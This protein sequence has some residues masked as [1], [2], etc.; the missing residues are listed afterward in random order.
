MEPVVG[1]V[2]HPE[3]QYGLVILSYVI[4]VFGSFV[5]L[6]CAQSM[7]RP[8]GKTDWPMTIGAAISLGGVGIW[9]MH[10][11][12]MIAYKVKVDIGYALIPTAISLVAAIV[13][14]G[15]ALFLAGGRGYFRVSGWLMGSVLA[16]VG[17][18]V[19]H[20]LGTYAM[21]LRA[22][23]T[24]EPEM[25]AASV[26][27]AIVASMAALWL[28][29]HVS[30]FVHRLLAACAMGVAV[31][32]MHYVGM[33]AMNLICTATE[34]SDYMVLRGQDIHL[35]TL[36]IAGAVLSYIYFLAMTRAIKHYVADRKGS[37]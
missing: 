26:G 1:Q 7:V 31:C 22:T 17:V 37:A 11:V 32:A 16:G 4:S 34:P 28:A 23:L 13:I 24:L 14:A 20:Y 30:K 33:N 15:I 27:I 6:Q 25:V 8:D 5:A 21:S 18:A 19:M 12:G 2:L 35:W 10:F 3:Y 9:T 29:F 36:V